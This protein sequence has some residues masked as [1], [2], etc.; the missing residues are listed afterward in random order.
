[1]KAQFYEDATGFARAPATNSNLVASTALAP[2]VYRQ[3]SIETRFSINRPIIG[4]LKL[5]KF[6][7]SFVEWPIER[8]RWKNYYCLIIRGATRT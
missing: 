6:R 1:M 8:R 3:C 2:R 4:Y 5:Y 7:I